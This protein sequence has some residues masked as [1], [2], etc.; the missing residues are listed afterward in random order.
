ME[1]ILREDVPNLGAMGEVVRVK[2]GYGR[3][4]LLPRGLAVEASRH[5]LAEL[6]HQKRLVADKRERERKAARGVADKIDGLV[7]EVKVRAGEEDRLYGSVTNLDLERLLTE[8]GYAV[9]RKR[10][11][12]TEP[13]KRLGTYRIPIGIVHDVKA[14]ITL[15]V[16]RDAEPEEQA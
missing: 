9:D 11:D 3:N 12:L 8:R 4:Y 16:L 7:L 2:P 13:I 15:K 14:T 5:N 10:I 1:V 6:E